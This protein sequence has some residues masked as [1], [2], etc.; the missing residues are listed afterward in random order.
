MNFESL[1]YAKLPHNKV[2]C[3]ICQRR[4]KIKEGQSGFCHTRINI[5][6]MLFS[7]TYG[8]VTLYRTAP[9]EIKPVYHYL[10]GSY[11]L[12]LGS[13]GCNFLCPGCQNWDISFALEKNLL[14]NT[15]YMSPETV[16]QLAL[17]FR[18]QGISW[19][20]NEP[21]LWFEYTLH[22]ARLAKESGLYTNYVTNGYITQEALD[23]IGPFLDI[24][25][26]DV[27]GFSDQ[28]Y[29]GISKVK[30]WYAILDNIVHAKNRWH[31]HIELVTN[32]IPNCN[33]DV[34]QLRAL[35]DWIV[36]ELGPHTPWHVTR[37]YPHWRWHHLPSTPVAT[38]E[39]IYE[40]AKNAGLHYVYI[41]NVPGHRANHTY[42][43]KCGEMVI[44][45]DD[46]TSIECRIENN[47]CPYCGYP[48]EGR[49]E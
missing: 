31:M 28:A 6:G 46:L 37:F 5:N 9:I 10:P 43:P 42:C 18:C 41:G 14:K 27:K 16:I 49:W 1:L 23:E 22:S 12:S 15:A 24:F 29:Y 44:K 4:C 38:L 33:D 26:V 45:R 19:T 13:L 17:K 32:I 7:T 30:K 36:S 48:I 25:R 2:Q 21:T 20:Y 34:E 35:A 39:K 3:N 11:A 40:L 47:A 8:E